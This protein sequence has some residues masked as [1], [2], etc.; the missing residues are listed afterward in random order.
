LPPAEQRSQ[1][2]ADLLTYGASYEEIASVLG[3]TYHI[4]KKAL[5][6]LYVDYAVS[7]AIGFAAAH[8]E[9]CQQSGHQMSHL[10]V[11]AVHRHRGTPLQPRSPFRAAL[12]ARQQ[13]IMELATEG[14]EQGAIAEAMGL[15]L[16]RVRAELLVIY[17]RLGA[18]SLV[19]AVRIW[20]EQRESQA[21]RAAGGQATEREAA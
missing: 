12:T 19:D 21:G 16:A 3:I 2:I 1:D 17:K 18:R 15:P 8:R 6:D 13:S 20:L 5:A 11:E 9:R 14:R 10:L 7:S 4:V